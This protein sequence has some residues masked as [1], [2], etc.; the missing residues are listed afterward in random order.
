MPFKVG[1][2]TG[3]YM[4]ARSE[5]ISTVL[6]K[7]GAGLTM[8]T[9]AIEMA[10]DIPHEI[11]I[12]DGLA[13]HHMA[14]KQSIDITLHG[15]LTV[16]LC[17]PERGDWRDAH[18]HMQKAIR[19]AVYAGAKYVN[20][21]TCLREWL[22]LFTYA[23]SKL[24]ITM[25]DHLGRFISEILHDNKRLRDWFVGKMDNLGDINYASMILNEEEMMK[26]RV[27]VTVERGDRW[28]SG[29]I[30]ERLEEKKKELGLTRE[31]TSPE[32]LKEFQKKA[33]VLEGFRRPGHKG[34][35]REVQYVH[36][37]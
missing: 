28:A 16:P 18:N 24:T 3:I 25:C 4:A 33:K 17:M 13:I 37:R 23:G 1:V 7:L 32:E 10:E 27:R 30:E 31:P 21:H 20:H 22:E 34:A 35:D 36:E 5:E 19:A 26:I 6:R 11:T 9:G 29:E 2:S 12:S 15:P 14:K 8:G